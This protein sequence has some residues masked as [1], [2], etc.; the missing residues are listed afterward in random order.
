MFNIWYCDF[1]QKNSSILKVFLVFNYNRIRIR[2]SR[3]T[4]S[5]SATLVCNP[6]VA[7]RVNIWFGL[8]VCLRHRHMVS[9]HG[10]LRTGLFMHMPRI[11]YGEE[12]CWNTGAY[13][14]FFHMGKERVGRVVSRRLFMHMPQH[15]N[16]I[17]GKEGCCNTGAYKGFFNIGS[18]GELHCHD[19]VSVHGNLTRGLFM[20]MPQ[21]NKIIH[22]KEGWCNTGAATILL[23][24]MVTF[25]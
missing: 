25:L 13:K 20:N 17:H 15:N 10:N 12:G 23:R 21:H 9:V 19:I 16:S 2:P 8:L 4:G 7:R 6:C 5:V 14:G 3:R 24:C 18:G 22:E 11:I 1:D